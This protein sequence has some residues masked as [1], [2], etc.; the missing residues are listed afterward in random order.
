M[1]KM[2]YKGVSQTP[3]KHISKKIQAIEQPLEISHLMHEEY[4]DGYNTS[5]SESTVK[6]SQMSK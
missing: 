6:V 2:N 5:S 3:M 1:K 4:E